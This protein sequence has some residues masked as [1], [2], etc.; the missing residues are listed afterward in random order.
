MADSRIDD[1]DK[2]FVDEFYQ[3]L[4]AGLDKVPLA[5]FLCGKGLS[6]SASGRRDIRTYLQSM[7]EAE[8]KSTS[9]MYSQRNQPF[10]CGFQTWLQRRQK[11][12]KLCQ[13]FRYKLLY[14]TT[15][16]MSIFHLLYTN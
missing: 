8:I 14:L 10:L 12:E 6:S 3:S 15:S 5:V 4:S 2:L 9:S 11:Q 16:Q 1:R 7:L 13:N